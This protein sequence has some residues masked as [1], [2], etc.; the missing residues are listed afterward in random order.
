MLFNCSIEEN[1]A[2]GFNGKASS[3]EIESVAVSYDH[4]LIS[5][6]FTNINK[7]SLQFSVFLCVYADKVKCCRKW[8]MLMIS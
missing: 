8:L 3:A 7:T 4:L 2:Y 1:I 6:P 5:S